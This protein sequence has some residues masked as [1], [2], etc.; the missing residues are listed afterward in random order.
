V[1]LFFL[2]YRLTHNCFPRRLLVL[3]YFIDPVGI[4]ATLSP[5]SAQQQGTD[6]SYVQT[7][8]TDFFLQP[9]RCSNA[10]ALIRTVASVICPFQLRKID[11][12]PG[13]VLTAGYRRFHGVS[14]RCGYSA[15][16]HAPRLI[17]QTRRYCALD[18]RFGLI[19]TCESFNLLFLSCFVFPFGTP[20]IVRTTLPKGR[21]LQ[22]KVTRGSRLLLETERLS[23]DRVLIRTGF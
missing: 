23:H 18:V 9:E 19:R 12:S 17:R 3:C 10:I 11:I 6:P 7:A 1:A 5:L 20:Q 16:S 13:N 8:L 14:E 22:T 2:L 4:E 21:A 15:N